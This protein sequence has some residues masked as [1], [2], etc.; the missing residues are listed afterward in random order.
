M[1]ADLGIF[2]TTGTWLGGYSYS[3]YGEAR[4]TDTGT[5][6]ST[7]SLCYI[8]GY[9]DTDAGLYRLGARYYDPGTGRF[10]QFDP[11]G[12]EASPYG[13][14]ACDPVAVTD[15]VIAAAGIAFSA[16]LIGAAATNP[17]TLAAGAAAAAALTA[18]G[19]AFTGGIAGVGL[20]IY[21]LSS[22]I[23]SVRSDC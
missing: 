13:Y 2:S 4:S 22:G 9:W 16:I 20:G 23:A 19:I 15:L 1:R 7:N 3:P 11:S 12:Q 8:S 18:S 21:S 5:A 6:P 14:A 17:V 10:T